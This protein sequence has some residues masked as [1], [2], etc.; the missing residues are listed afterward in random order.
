M[1]A[2]LPSAWGKVG[3]TSREPVE[4]EAAPGCAASL[5]GTNL[6]IMEDGGLTRIQCGT[7]ANL[8]ALCD[9]QKIYHLRFSTGTKGRSWTSPAS[10]RATGGPTG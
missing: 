8:Q 7:R 3:S 1:F 6:E 4:A 5:Y 10:T 9:T 2:L